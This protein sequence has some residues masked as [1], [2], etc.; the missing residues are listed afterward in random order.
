MG[1]E[2]APRA[3]GRRGPRRPPAAPTPPPC[4]RPPRPPPPPPQ[5]PPPVVKKG[6]LAPR[7]AE[8]TGRVGGAESEAQKSKT[9][10]GGAA[11]RRGMGPDRLSTASSSAASSSGSTSACERRRAASTADP[12]RSCEFAG[13]SVESMSAGEAAIG[14]HRL[15]MR[16]LCQRAVKRVVA[17]GR[18]LSLPMPRRRRGVETP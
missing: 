2:R 1:G 11:G 12:C 9:E 17:G 15:E 5:P 18:C 4:A 3:G 14:D 10:G 8:Q 7:C 13:L 16:S 6:G